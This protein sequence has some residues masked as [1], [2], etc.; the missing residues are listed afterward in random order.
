MRVHDL[1]GTLAV[2]G[3]EREVL[4]G[5]DES[6]N[7]LLPMATREFV[8]ILRHTRLPGHDFDDGVVGLR[9]VLALQHPVHLAVEQLVPLF[10]SGFVIFWVADVHGFI[11]ALWFILA[12]P[13]VPPRKTGPDVRQAVRLYLAKGLHEFRVG[14]GQA[15]QQIPRPI[16]VTVDSHLLGPKNQRP[17]KTPIKTALVPNRSVFNVLS[18][19]THNTNNSRVASRHFIGPLNEV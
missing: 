13:H 12:T 8:S 2:D 3:I 11:L 14:V 6:D 10:E 17:H 1:V 15:L 19:I 16:A 18:R 4:L 5:H 7:P 9:L